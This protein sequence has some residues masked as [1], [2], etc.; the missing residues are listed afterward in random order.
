VIICADARKIPL[1]DRSVQCVVT[2][3]PYWGLRDY[4]TAKWEGGDPACDHNEKRGGRSPETSAKQLTN[5]GTVDIQYRDVCRKCQAKRVDVQIGLEATPADYVRQLVS[6]FADVRRIL[7]DDGTVWLN[8]GDT[9]SRGKNGRDDTFGDHAA[10]RA[11]IFGSGQGDGNG[12]RYKTTERPVPDGLKEKDLVGI[13][14]RSA[15]ALQGFAVVPFR[16]FSTWADEL[17]QARAAQDWDAVAIV[18][19]KLRAMDLLAGLQASG[20]YLRA[21]VIWSKPNPMPES[22]TDRTTKAHEF[23]FLLT[24][25]ERYVYDADAIAEPVSAAMLLEIDQGY[26]G[27]GLKDYAAAGVQD[28]SDVKSRIIENARRKAMT[29]NPRPGIDAQGNQGSVIG[30]PRFRKEPTRGEGY[31]AARGN[32]ALG[33]TPDRDGGFAPKVQYLGKTADT[34]PDEK[35]HRLLDSLAEARAAGAPHDVPFGLTRNKRSVWTISSLA[36]RG[37]HFATMPPALVEPCILAGSRLAGR[38]CDCD[39][40]IATPLGDDAIV[41]PSLETGRAGMNRP[42]LPGQGVRPMTRREQ[43]AYAEQLRQSEHRGQM[44]AETVAYAHD[45][46]FDQASTIPASVVAESQTFAHYIRTDTAGARAIPPALLELWTDRGWLT[47]PAPCDHPVEPADIVFDPFGGSGTVG[48]VAERLGRRWVLTD[49]NPK[50]LGLQRERTAQRGFAF[51]LPDD[52][53]A[54]TGSR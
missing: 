42:R 39:D 48:E 12:P 40:I 25:S 34:A 16:S 15:F 38:R 37:A 54:G 1:A 19:Q 22:V 6:V 13:P 28:P 21:D 33:N 52:A 11:E 47:T 44:E 2:S 17:A 46:P 18:E 23:V 29:R 10:R 41:D 53:A 27:L 45:L 14:W 50:Y 49:L 36:Y 4:G 26:D 24:K 31:G 5:N 30:I 51:E 20:W 9:Y 35:A 3:P 43:R 8:L 7:K 32:E